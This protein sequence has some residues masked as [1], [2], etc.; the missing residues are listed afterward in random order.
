MECFAPRNPCRRGDS[1]P[2]TAFA[3][4]QKL[5]YSSKRSAISG[6]LSVKVLPFLA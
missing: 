3:F 5:L 6:Q 2:E 1:I 4:K